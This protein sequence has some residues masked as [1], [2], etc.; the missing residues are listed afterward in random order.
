MATPHG[1]SVLWH[2]EETQIPCERVAG[3]I[4]QHAHD[5]RNDLNGIDL[6]SALLLELVPEGEARSGVDRIRKQV[7]SLAQKF[8]ALSARFH[9]G[10]PISGPMPASALLSIWRE[11]H[12]ALPNPPEVTWQ[13][14]SKNAQVSADVEM[15]AEVFQELLNNAITFEGAGPLVISAKVDE[16]LVTFELREPKKSS[17]DPL[18]WGAP[19]FSTRRGSYGLGLWTARRMVEANKGT[20]VQRYVPEDS[21]LLTQIIL[22]KVG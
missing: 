13:D 6:E 5:V 19:F 21:A 20:F 10:Q 22:P 12:G 16:D 15:L 18:S 2:M 11:R 4:R 9:I 3:F 17:V 14:N 7:R 8:R 1:R